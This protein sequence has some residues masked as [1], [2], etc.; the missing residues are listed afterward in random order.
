MNPIPFLAKRAAPA[1][2]PD[3]ILHQLTDKRSLA[4]PTCVTDPVKT[5]M[6]SALESS[7]LLESDLLE[8]ISRET[9]Y[10]PKTCMIYKALLGACGD[11]AFQKHINR[12]LHVPDEIWEEATRL[13][14]QLLDEQREISRHDECRSSAHHDYRKKGPFLRLLKPTTTRLPFTAR[15]MYVHRRDQ[16]VDMNGMHD[17]NPPSA[18]EMQ[19]MIA[20]HPD[21]CGSGF[22]RSA[23]FRVYPIV[24]GYR[25]HRLPDEIHTYDAHGNLF[26]SGGVLTPNP[27]GTSS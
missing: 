21:A 9:D 27:P 10:D 8:I 26:A 17:F 14:S 3:W 4:N 22:L 20:N 2:L 19:S 16:T 5:L 23:F 1:P 7:G 18:R 11:E 13:R 6:S 15:I 24:G 12:I 25:Y